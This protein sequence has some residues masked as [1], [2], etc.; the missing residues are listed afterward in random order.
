M[1]SP[2]EKCLCLN[3]IPPLTTQHVQLFTLPKARLYAKHHSKLRSVEE[4]SHLLSCFQA[5]PSAPSSLLEFLPIPFPAPFIATDSSHFPGQLG[6]KWSVCTCA[7]IS[8]H[9]RL[10]AAVDNHV[11]CGLG[12]QKAGSCASMNYNFPKQRYLFLCIWYHYFDS[13]LSP[14]HVIITFLV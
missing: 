14:A 5:Y 4:H 10:N 3:L 9:L 2:D 13:H 6:N 1:R 8:C 12:P 11:H 7:P